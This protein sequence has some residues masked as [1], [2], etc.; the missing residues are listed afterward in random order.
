MTD[1]SA[2]SPTVGLVKVG[3]KMLP[4]ADA[5]RAVRR[6]ANWFWWVAGLS[7]INSVAAAMGQKYRMVLGLGVT[8]LLDAF[9]PSGETTHLILVLAVTGLFFLLGFYARR[10]SSTSYIAGMVVYAADALLFIPAADWIAVG[11]H[12]FVL[13]MLWGGYLTLRSIKE[14]SAGG[15][16]AAV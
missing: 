2:S 16:D 11:F 3:T 7:L 5:E 8:Q 13:F 14:H 10:Y 4:L 1:A 9:F 6:S 15:T 12:A